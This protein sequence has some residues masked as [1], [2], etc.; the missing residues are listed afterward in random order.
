M[1][2]WREVASRPIGTFFAPTRRFNRL[3]CDQRSLYPPAITSCV[4][5]NGTHQQEVFRDPVDREQASAQDGEGDCHAADGR[6]SAEGR[7]ARISH[8]GAVACRRATGPQGSCRS[9]ETR[10]ESVG[11]RWERVRE[12]PRLFRA[13][14]QPAEIARSLH[15]TA[16]PNPC[17]RLR[18]PGLFQCPIRREISATLSCVD[19]RRA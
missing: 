12:D 6:R 2:R 9:A 10:V 16:H 1:R 17:R 7:K 14:W 19:L 18:S 8:H 4:R 11:E 5:A 13:T 15:D 3:E